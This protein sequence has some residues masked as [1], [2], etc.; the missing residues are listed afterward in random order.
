MN[1]RANLYAALVKAQQSVKPVEKDSKNSFHHYRY[2]SSEDV[3]SESRRALSSCGLAFAP[4]SYLVS[5]DESGM[6]L[7]ALYVLAHESGESM[8]VRSQTPIIPEKGRPEDKATATAK[9]YNL[10][11]TL[12]GVLLIERVEEGVNA[13][14]RDDSRYIPKQQREPAGARE[15]QAEARGEKPKSK[16]DLWRDGWIN[17]LGLDLFADTCGVDKKDAGSFM[18]PKDKAK[19]DALTATLERTKADIDLLSRSE[20]RQ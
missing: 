13:D 17:A 16:V 3:I 4:T 20:E 7:S 8:E 6:M 1:S 10:A 9:T 14:A 11:Y 5:H 15:V 2:A 12:R 18:P 19:R